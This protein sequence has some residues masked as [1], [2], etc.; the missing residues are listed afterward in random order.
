[1]SPLNTWTQQPPPVMEQ[2]KFSLG[3]Y[4]LFSAIIGGLPLLLA[5]CLLY[6]PISG[7]QDLAPIIKNNASLAIAFTLLFLSYILG[8]T[9]QNLTW[10]YFKNLCK[11]FRHN[12]NYFGDLIPKRHQQLQAQETQLHQPGLEFEDRLVLLLQQHIGIPKEIKWIDQR[13]TA[14]LKEHQKE[15]TLKTAELHLANHIMYR[16][17]SF[18]FYFLSGVLLLN[19]FR[20]P[21]QTLELWLLPVL[22]LSLAYLTFLQALNLKRWNNR[23]LL[24]G[25]YFAASNQA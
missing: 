10:K 22:S 19:L 6:S 2:L 5:C 11:L 14:Y 25:F 9:V 24:L 16:T 15:A 18:G 17:W 20:A 13:I 8:G 12:Y 4:E 1:M 23:E 7:L 3:P 21:S